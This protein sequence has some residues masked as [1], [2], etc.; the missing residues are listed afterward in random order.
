MKL[1][2]TRKLSQRLSRRT[3]LI[4]TAAFLSIATLV[5]TGI[6]LFL[7][8]GNQKTALAAPATAIWQ[9]TFNG[10]TNNS[11]SD[12]GS[13]A[14]SV[15]LPTGGASS[16]SK[17]T[18]V[19]G[20]ELFVINNTTSEGV[21]R[22]SVNNISAY[23]EVAIEITLYSYFTYATDYIRCYYKVD[24][25]PEI[26][27]GE[28]LGSNGLN[29]TSAA[30]AIVSGATVQIVVRAKENTPGTS[31]TYG[32]P[33]IN[34]LAFDD[35]T[36]TSIAVLY[37]RTSGNW[38]NTSTW[39]TVGLGG[40]SCS[41]F[42]DEDSRVVIG[43]NHTIAITTASTTAGIS[44]LNTG[45]LRFTGNT[46]MTMA[47]GGTINVSNGGS[48]IKNGQNTSS[49]A[50]GAYAYSITVNGSLSVG[51][52]DASTGSNLTLNGTGT[53]DLYGDLLLAS[54]SGRTIT[55]NISGN[56]TIGNDLNF[57]P[58]S[59]NIS[60]VNN[61]KLSVT[62]RILFNDDNISFTNNGTLTVGANGLVVND[63]GD[64]N[65]VFNNTSTGIITLGA[66]NLNSA[67]FTLNNA[68][69]IT[70]SGS[71]SNIITASSVNNQNGGTWNFSG[72]GTNTRLFT[73][74]G[75]NT[76]NYAAA[77]AQTI[78]TPADGAYSNLT[79]SGSGTKTPSANL[80]VNGV[81]A[82]SGTAQLDVTATPYNLSVGGD[83]TLASTNANIIN[84]RTGTITFD[85][86]ANQSFTTAS[87]IL[88]NVTINKS[89]GNLVLSTGSNLTVSN[90]LNLTSGG[91]DLNGNML[92]VTRA[93]ATAI[94][95]SSGFIKSETT[96]SPYSQVRWSVGTT[97]GTYIFPFAK[98]SA[99]NY[100]PFTFQV[101]TAG[102]GAGTV[103]LSTYATGTA[104]TPYPS[105]VLNVNKSVGEDNSSNTV[106]RF[107]NINLNGYTVNPVVNITFVAAATE[108]G[109]ISSLKAQR[110]NTSTSKWDAPL[111][112]QSN[113]NSY[114]VTVN[115]VSQ[116]SPW[117]LVGGST[118]L[119]I[120][121]LSF[122]AT[123]IDDKVRLNW[124]TTSE[125]NNDFFTVE[126]STD[127]KTFTRV[128]EV[129]GSGNSSSKKEYESY[130]NLPFPG[131]SYYRLKQTDYDGKYEYSQLVVINFE[132][133]DGPKLIVYPTLSDGTYLNI[134]ITGMQD[135]ASEIPVVIF[136]QSGQK[137][138]ELL[139]P[140]SNESKSGEDKVQFDNRLQPGFYI[141]RVGN[142]LATKIW[143]K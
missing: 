57:Q 18:P 82:I 41:C 121:L 86:A 44:V 79:L 113:P 52:I 11:T 94:I 107:W 59:A 25:G 104:N 114:S 88:Y 45:T 133:G 96:G 98:S 67:D 80:D 40:T 105:G 95:R 130:D 111:S 3:I 73:N 34:A 110:W 142:K 42:P 75:T 112:G 131:K 116:F 35:V 84:E 62:N 55:N 81:L 127:G 30:S 102:T 39:S 13:T 99:T 85:G 132:Q 61:G 7:N 17:Q 136:N 72:G 101:A 135:G 68:G 126:S 69:R 32:F 23:T 128:S 97:T 137:V 76:F 36:L 122:K 27:F 9:E 103:S 71:F 16:F 5:G 100:I 58:G 37:S 47:R 56:L 31:S 120:E 19:S 140:Y 89:A 14:W 51:R 93:N 141:V 115:N 143:V 78:F 24:G 26:Q 22:S 70:Q 2:T 54:S 108:V 28:L 43:N 6:F 129:K 87:E 10:L 38:E 119:P 33:I 53:M 123:V 29:I 91:L 134:K 12:A 90:T 106:D 117:T 21:W 138:Y 50:Y 124:V 8:L 60:F 118:T 48:F 125:R 4:A 64:D 65:T 66:I 109:G 1:K 77:G 15:T 63:N 74:N 83:I 139:L 49:I 46:S 92:S 20:Y